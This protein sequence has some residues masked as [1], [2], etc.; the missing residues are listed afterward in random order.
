MGARLAR[1]TKNDTYARRAEKAWDWMWDRNYIDHK[2]WAAYDGAH[3]DKNCTDVNKV[4]FSYNAG[5]LVQGAAFMYNYV[6]PARRA[7]LPRRR[8]STNTA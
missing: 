8:P 1:Y 3:V 6:C 2:S 7:A 4:T 5:V